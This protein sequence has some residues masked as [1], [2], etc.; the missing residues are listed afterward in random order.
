[1]ILPKDEGRT[2]PAGPLAGIRVLD[3]T[4]VLM[5][6]YCT[7]L[8]ADL[9]ADVIKVEAPS[10]DTTRQLGK[11]TRPGMSGMFLN[12]NR[13]KRGLVLDLRDA[14]ARDALNR[15]VARSDVFIHSNRPRAAEKLGID[16]ASIAA[17]NPRIVYCGLYGFGRGGRYFGQPAYDDIIQA[18]SGMAKLQ[19][20]ASGTPG[21]VASSVADKVCSLTAAYAINAALLHRERTGEGQEIDV[22]MFETVV[23]FLFAQHLTG[24]A[25]DPPLGRP[26]YPRVVSRLRRPHRTATD[27]ICVLIYN[28]KHWR[29]FLDIIDRPDLLT[30]PRFETLAARSTN[31]EDYFAL[32]DA[33]LTRRPAAEWCALFEAAEIPVAPMRAVDDV[34]SDG[35]LAD[36]DFWMTLESGDGRQRLPRPPVQFSRTPAGISGPAPTLGEHTTEILSELGYSAAEIERLAQ[37]SHAGTEAA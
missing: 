27:D 24:S 28:D 3:L 22:P 30:D 7:Q 4:S 29:R 19:E 2:A 10:G 6:P 13:G 11:S 20:E 26:A 14:S 9:G 37:P 16:Y 34:L 31:L 35:H 15:L 25:F 1:M 36:V 21:Y 8:L 32:I 12:L 5:G 23:S 18:A 33:E 17:I